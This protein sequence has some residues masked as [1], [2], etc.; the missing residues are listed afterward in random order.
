METDDD[1][2]YYKPIPDERTYEQAMIKA[3]FLIDNGY[4]QLTSGLTYESIVDQLI[5]IKTNDNDQSLGSYGTF[6]IQ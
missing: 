5:N 2:F 3:T 1:K 6:H 4:V